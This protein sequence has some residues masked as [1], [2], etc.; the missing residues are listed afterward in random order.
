MKHQNIWHLSK[1][2]IIFVLTL[3]LSGCASLG[4][5][6]P[7]L[8]YAGNAHPA[9]LNELAQTNPLFVQELGKLPEIQDGISEKEM[10]VLNDIVELY[11]SDQENF[12]NSFKY[13]RISL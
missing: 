10:S 4:P 6:K 7:N 5:T 8:P 1:F 12:D 3:Y 13:W 11:R 2:I 9:V